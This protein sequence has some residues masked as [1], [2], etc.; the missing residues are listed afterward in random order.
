MDGI[1]VPSEPVFSE[2]KKIIQ[3]L[4]LQYHSPCF[5]PHLTVLGDAGQDLKAIQKTVEKIVADMKKMKLSLGPLSFSTTY[6]QSAFVRVNSTASL[7]QLNLDL[8]KLLNME[9]DIFMPHMS[10]IY[11]NHDMKTRE[12]IVKKTKLNNSLFVAEKMV[13]IPLKPDLNDWKPIFTI[14]LV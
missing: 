10:L 12:D 4:S 3:D 13:V 8:K 9:N 1:V 7:M 2:L 14:P 11:G 5:D 6:F